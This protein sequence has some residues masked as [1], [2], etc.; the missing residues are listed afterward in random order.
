MMVITNNPLL[1]GEA[2]VQF[3]EG[4]FRD[5]LV[6]VR[7]LVYTGHELV[8]HPLFASLGMM[9]SPYRTVILG[10]GTAEPSAE[11]AC[12][13]EDSIISYDHVTQGR[14]RVEWNDEDYARMDYELYEAACRECGAVPRWCGELGR[15]GQ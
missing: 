10:E 4:G 8:S 14:Q 6:R 12:I 2:D 5:V 3:V 11:H 7:D 1:R 9:F 15:H 13:I